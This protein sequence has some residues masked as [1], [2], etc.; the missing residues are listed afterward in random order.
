[1]VFRARRK[2][3][4]LLVGGDGKGSDFESL[5]E[6]CIER[7]KYAILFGRDASLVEQAMLS[8]VP[9]ACVADL[10]SAVSTAKEIAASGDVVLLSPACAS[11]DQFDDYMARG[12]C[13][14]E[15]VAE[16]RT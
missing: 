14:A 12:D 11:F 7:V 13:F 5:G 3:I 4:V 6:A 15:C 10:N 8:R 2:N 16:L 1:M 9:T